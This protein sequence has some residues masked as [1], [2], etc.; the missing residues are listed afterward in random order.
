MRLLRACLLFALCFA[1]AACGDDP[2][3]AKKKIEAMGLAFTP[4]AMVEQVEKGNLEAFDLFLKA[5]MPITGQSAAT[6]KTP[7]LAAVEK[8]DAPLIAQ[9]LEKMPA[10]EGDAAPVNAQDKQGR[11]AV[12]VAAER[13]DDALLGQLFIKGAV[14]FVYDASQNTPVH[15]AARKGHIATVDLLLKTDAAVNQGGQPRGLN[16]SNNG[17]ETPLFMAAQAGN[18]GMIDLLLGYKPDVNGTDRSGASPLMAAVIAGSLESVEKLAEAGAM[19]DVYDINGNTPLT[20]AIQK[21][22]KDI[23]RKLI[24]QGADT[25]FHKDDTPLPVQVV[26][27]TEPLDYDLFTLMLSKSKAADKVMS[28]VLFDAVNANNLDA[29]RNL[30]DKGVNPNV[31]NEQG[32]TLLLEALNA[33]HQDMVLLLIDRGADM[34]AAQSSKVSLLEIAVRNNMP[35]LAKKL[36]DKD[37]NPNVKT[38][39]GYSLADICVYRGY[40]EMLDMLIAKGANVNL[41][42]SIL[43]SIRDGGGKAVT[44][45][46]K[47]GGNPNVMN[48]QKEPALWLAISANQEEAALALIKHKSYVNVYSERIGTTALGVA[49]YVG[50]VTIVKAL[51]ENG[52]TVDQVDKVGITALGYAANQLKVEAVRYLLSKGANPRHADKQGRTPIDLASATQQSAAREEVLKLLS[53][54][55]P[56]AK[57]PVPPVQPA[58]PPAAQP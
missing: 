52:A 38:P 21:G 57:P 28:D 20:L 14:A 26:L 16:F 6:G 31:T 3:E 42:F 29:L 47:H 4:D 24:A 33:G 13:G 12:I 23:A 27:R 19:L 53:E 9:I 5:G 37:A 51:I 40:A 15:L 35:I 10:G 30:L 56:Q 25:D 54:T 41:D 50:N 11:N 55:P 18:A 49:A 48:Q 45:L 22:H 8:N 1:V 58:Q 39:D 44:V 46:L 7:L 2:D 36:L 34:A 32:Q 43:W 17:A